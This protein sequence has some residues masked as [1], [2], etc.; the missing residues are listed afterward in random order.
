MI[1][2][3]EQAKR[4]RPI[5]KPKPKG[6]LM[7]YLQARSPT[8]AFYTEVRDALYHAEEEGTAINWFASNIDNA[9]TWADTPQ[10]DEYWSNIH[11]KLEYGDD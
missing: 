3:N 2:L 11:G 4:E 5:P 1:V 8:L 6:D 10:G 9:M 7:T